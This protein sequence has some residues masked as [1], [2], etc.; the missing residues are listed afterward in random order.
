MRTKRKSSSGK[1]DIPAIEARLT[2][3][4][5]DGPLPKIVVFDIDYTL[6][7]LW[8]DTHC[9]GPPFRKAERGGFLDRGGG[10]IDLAPHA[11]S[12]I[13]ALH[14]RSVEIGLA[15][16][17]DEPEWAEEGLKLIDVQTHS[18]N[19]GNGGSGGGSSGS[20][21]IGSSGGGGGSGGSSGG[22]G[23]S[24]SGGGSSGSGSGGS[25]M[26]LHALAAYR[27]IYP[28][29]K[30]THFR[31]IQAA[32]GGVPFGDMLFFDDEHRNVLEVARLGVVCHHIPDCICVETFAAGLEA[33]RRSASGG[34]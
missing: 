12:V 34:D 6:W 9:A 13:A 4:L 1:V 26:T 23:G 28:G 8:I 5:D 29:G 22:G 16:R 15:S 14:A 33:F 19:G 31:R 27:E 2:E 11:R 20:G 30:T 24:G 21:H 17:T 7:P 10:H 3:L 18:S 32:A 25:V